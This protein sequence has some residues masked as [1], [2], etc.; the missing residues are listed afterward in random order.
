MIVITP[1]EIAEL[2]AYADGL[3]WETGERLRLLIDAYEDVEPLRDTLEGVRLILD[4]DDVPHD[5]RVCRAL[6][7]VDP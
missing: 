4:D 5:E 3:K 7:E 2:R 6:K 1:H